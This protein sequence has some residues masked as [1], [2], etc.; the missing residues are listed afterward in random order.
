M[1]AR[2]EAAP[3]KGRGGRLFNQL[4][5]EESPAL[6]NRVFDWYELH[7]CTVSV[8]SGVHV[9]TRTIG[10]LRN[11]FEVAVATPTIDQR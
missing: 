6:G 8:S 7:V 9:G 1:D 5:A 10:A 4:L 3:S 11:Q 2:G